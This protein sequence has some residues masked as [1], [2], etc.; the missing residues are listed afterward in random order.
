M[1]TSEWHEWGSDM[2]RV[3]INGPDLR[4]LQCPAKRVGLPSSY[5]EPVIDMK[6]EIIWLYSYHI[7]R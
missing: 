7:E 4:G 5:K 1:T 6:P 3:E 2:G